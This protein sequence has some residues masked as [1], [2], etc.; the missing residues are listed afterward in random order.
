MLMFSL[1]RSKRRLDRIQEDTKKSF[2][3]VK[4]DISSVTG[5]IKHLDSEKNIQKKE[6]DELKSNVSSINAEVEGL[7]NLISLIVDSGTNRSFKQSFK[8]NPRVFSKQTGVSPV[9]TDVQTSVQTLELNYFSITERAILLVLLNTDMKLSYEDLAAMLGKEKS[10]I[11][12]Q[13]NSIKAKSESLIEET[14]GINGKKRIYISEKVK[15][16]LLKRAKVRIKK[17]PFKEDA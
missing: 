11:R 15:E 6:L 17:E 13:I 8:T 1:F 14:I 9:Q 2:E 7:K 10:T 4:K 3:L 16:T 12:G 5:W